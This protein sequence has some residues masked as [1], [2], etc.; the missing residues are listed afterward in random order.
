[1]DFGIRIFARYFAYHSPDLLYRCSIVNTGNISVPGFSFSCF[2]GASGF[3]PDNSVF[4]NISSSWLDIE[5]SLS[6]FPALNDLLALIVE[7]D[8]V[9]LY[10]LG[11]AFRNGVVRYGAQ[12]IS[13]VTHR[14]SCVNYT[15][16]NIIILSVCRS[17]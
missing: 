10:R 12:S 13:E 2:D 14:I 8:S 1:M 17:V 3:S 6:F 11:F 5:F 4:F 7:P 16:Y 9:D 15:I